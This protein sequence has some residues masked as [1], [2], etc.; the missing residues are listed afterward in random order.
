M[1][2]LTITEAL[3]EIKTIE[4]RVAKKK[5]AI[6]PHIY[7]PQALRDPH[8]A[9]GG[10]AEYIKR[11]MQA[12]QD[13]QERV[14]TLRRAIATAN[15]ETNVMI[16]GE[17][18]PIADWLIWRREVLPKKK[19]L[20]RDIQGRV[21]AM[22]QEAQNKGI[23]VVD[24]SGAGYEDVI[25][26]INEADLASEIEKLEEIEGTLDGQLSLK[27]ATTFVKI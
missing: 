24:K 25:V 14:V 6:L 4:K 12:A 7:R 2:K 27:N 22:R 23:N 10:S 13:L 20:L 5:E 18:R 19:A 9:S 16:A 1:S 11:E 26:N 15:D 17:D 8:E 21:I 3:A